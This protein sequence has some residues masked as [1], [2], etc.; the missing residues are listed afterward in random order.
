MLLKREGGGHLALSISR[1]IEIIY[2]DKIN[3]LYGKYKMGPV[4]QH[5]WLD[6]VWFN[7]FASSTFLVWHLRLPSDITLTI[8]IGSLRCRRSFLISTRGEGNCERVRKTVRGRVG[9]KWKT[10][11]AFLSNPSS[12]SCI[13]FSHPSPHLPIPFI[14]HP[15]RDRLLVGNGKKTSAFQSN[16]R[17]L[18][19]FFLLWLRHSCSQHT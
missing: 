16:C 8:T 1:M 3:S 13:F 6:C 4:A 9:Q 5:K 10:I 2:C 18:S 7:L 15:R 11:I 19:V 12:F 14:A 17:Y